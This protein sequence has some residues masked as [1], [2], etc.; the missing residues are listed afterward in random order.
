MSRTAV[1]AEEAETSG[2]LRSAD[3]LAH[4]KGPAPC[5]PVGQCRDTRPR[6][7]KPL[8]G[9]VP[10]GAPGET[11]RAGQLLWVKADALS[12]EPIRMQRRL[13]HRV[14]MVAG[15][16]IG[17]RSQH[18]GKTVSWSAFLD[19]L[20]DQA[21][22]RRTRVARGPPSQSVTSNELPGPLSQF[23][24]HLSPIPGS[25]PWHNRQPRICRSPTDG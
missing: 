14:T 9:P 15:R 12:S 22:R 1:H 17:P 11:F 18:Q 21:R 20:G 16:N 19:Q 2:F 7:T 3:A 25:N 6:W 24:D 10:P 13:R 4:P 5:R 23:L 8:R